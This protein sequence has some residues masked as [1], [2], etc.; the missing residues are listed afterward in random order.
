MCQSSVL[1]QPFY[2]RNRPNIHGQVCAWSINIRQCSALHPPFYH[3]NR[4]NMHGQVCAWPI[5][6][7]QY[8]VCHQPFKTWTDKTG[9]KTYNKSRLVTQVY[10]FVINVDID[11]FAF[12]VMYFDYICI[13]NITLLIEQTTDQL[14]GISTIVACLCFV[15]TLLKQSY[16]ILYH[17][18]VRQ[19]NGLIVVHNIWLKQLSYFYADISLRMPYNGL[20]MLQV[21]FTSRHWYFYLSHAAHQSISDYNS[22]MSTYLC[23]RALTTM[24]NFRD[25]PNYDHM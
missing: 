23:L 17:M 21:L 5:N 20:L 9:S 16:T 10:L 8:S 13:A 1:H 7:P 4:P 19:C 12:I 6:A 11:T 3:L 24:T 2:H 18:Y 25:S 22:R 14:R 15:Y